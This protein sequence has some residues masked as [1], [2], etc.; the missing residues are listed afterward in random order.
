MMSVWDTAFKNTVSIIIRYNN[1]EQSHKQEYTSNETIFYMAYNLY[2]AFFNNWKASI[3]TSQCTYTHQRPYEM[4]H[5]SDM[6]L[7]YF[8]L[9]VENVSKNERKCIYQ[10]V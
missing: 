5:T 2:K 3:V 8:S 1:K 7:M 9:M 4:V 10:D 6:L